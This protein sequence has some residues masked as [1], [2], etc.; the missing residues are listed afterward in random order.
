[1]TRR[2]LHPLAPWLGGVRGGFGPRTDAELLHAYTTGRDE[3]AFAELLRRHG[4]LVWHVCRR[5]LRHDQDAEDAFQATFL[6]LARGAGSI[7]TREAVASWLFGVARRTAL[8]VRARR[9]RQPEPAREARTEPDPVVT[10]GSAEFCEVILDTLRQLP[11]KYRLPL[12][13]CGVQGATKAEAAR[14]L[15]WKEGT[16]SGR[17]ARAR[18]LLE[19]R[20]LRRGILAPVTTGLTVTAVRRSLLAATL[21]L[22]RH[23]CGPAF[24]PAASSP[25]TLALEVLR[26]MRPTY[27]RFVFLALFTLVLAG[28]GGWAYHGLGRETPTDPPEPVATTA[29]PSAKGLPRWQE[30]LRLRGFAGGAYFAFSPDGK[31]F[32][33]SVMIPVTATDLPPQGVP[34]PMELRIFQWSAQPLTRETRGKPVEIKGGKRAGAGEGQPGIPGTPGTVPG[35][36]KP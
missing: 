30:R 5:L 10:V 25:A 26:S 19:R 35:P 22:V 16:L 14:Q 6:V 8:L 2:A 24:S 12:L 11:Q 29:R 1:M 31:T 27:G 34:T 17:L 7:R 9:N 33:L 18:R 21:A 4:P 20:L 36:G 13:L 32:V 28:A 15:G 3:D 23:G